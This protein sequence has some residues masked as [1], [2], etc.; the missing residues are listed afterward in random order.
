M[1]IKKINKIPF[2]ILLFII[3]TSLLGFSS[4]ENVQN[5]IDI[6]GKTITLKHLE[7]SY[8]LRLEEICSIASESQGIVIN[9][10]SLIKAVSDIAFQ[11]NKSAV[12]AKIINNK[13][14]TIQKEIDGEILDDAQL[15]QIIKEYLNS[16]SIEDDYVIDMPILIIKPELTEE[17]LNKIKSTEISTFSTKFSVK[18]V[19]RTENLRISTEDLNGTVIYPGEIFSLDD[20]LGERT[21]QK[22]YRYA[23][24]FSDGKT[25]KGLAGGI[26]QT[27]TTLYNTAL[28][29]NL[30]IVERHKHGLPVSY[31][32]KGR[33]ATVYR[34]VYD[35]RIKNN[36]EYPIYIKSYIDK[37]KGLLT[38]KIYGYK[39]DFNI[40]ITTEYQKK[41]GKSYYKTYRHVYD[42]NNKLIKKELISTDVFK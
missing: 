18:Q 26:C 16:G 19:D 17:I 30:E 34:N 23:P 24:I 41:D 36:T 27:S 35:L 6:N 14:F 15:T 13:S 38:A 5:P 32:N 22:G 3:T 25:V 4:R 12:D 10:G 2:F 40:K 21:V 37:K 42:L 20:K 28:F 31:I 9:E 7:N 8:T 33:D 11:I 29:A 39:K 1:K